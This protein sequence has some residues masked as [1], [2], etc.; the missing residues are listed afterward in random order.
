MSR[1]KTLITLLTAVVF[2]L[3]EM[4]AL[5]MLGQSRELS[6]IWLNRSSHAVLGS[7]WS[8]G[9]KV[10][11][12]FSLSEI[13]DAL[14]EENA[15]LSEELRAYR[16]AERAGREAGMKV[17]AGHGFEYIPATVTK[18]S[19][20]TVHNYIIINKGS[21]DGVTPHCGIITASGIV[22]IISAVDK[23]YSYGLTLMNNN[24]S[25]SSR[26]GRSGTVSPLVWDGERSD[27]AVLK[28]IPMHYSVEPGDTVYTSGFSN[29]F[30]ADIPIGTTGNTKFVDGATSRTEVFLFQDFSALRYVT[31]VKNP[32]R[33][34]IE[35]LEAGE[36]AGA[37]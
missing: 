23:H 24:I 5:A 12:H 27:R 8:H 35:A 31:V 11:T 14:S 17:D 19:R 2:I 32:E 7:L 21:E 15:A 28:D 13:N 36:E 37:E 26:A 34:E 6:D 9:E 4:A 18:M 25:V 1:R 20:G 30:P 16:E 22:G 29:I 3:M 10:R 33:A